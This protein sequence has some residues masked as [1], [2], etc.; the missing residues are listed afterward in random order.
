MELSEIR[1][2]KKK[3]EDNISEAIFEFQN[4]TGTVVGKVEVFT[5][6]TYTGYNENPQGVSVQISVRI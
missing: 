4:K 2:I 3:L 1:K 5:N 6:P